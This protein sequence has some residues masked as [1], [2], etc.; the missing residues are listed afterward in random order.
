MQGNNWA[1]FLEGIMLMTMRR[2]TWL[3]YWNSN[4]VLEILEDINHFVHES[5]EAIDTFFSNIVQQQNSENV[6]ES[7]SNMAFLDGLHST[8]IDISNR[9]QQ[10]PPGDNGSDLVFIFRTFWHVS[11][12]FYES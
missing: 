10:L 7:S 9:M 4:L 3:T 12:I 6:S 5:V 2:I 1:I 11:S 8:M